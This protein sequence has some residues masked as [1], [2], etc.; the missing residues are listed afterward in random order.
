[1]ALKTHEKQ[2]LLTRLNEHSILTLIKSIKPVSRTSTPKNGLSA[3][4]RRCK[5]NSDD[6]D[7]WTCEGDLKYNGAGYAVSF[8]SRHRRDSDPLSGGTVQVNLG[9][10]KVESLYA[11]IQAGW[12]RR[13]QLLSLHRD[14]SF[15][16]GKIKKLSELNVF[17]KRSRLWQIFLTALI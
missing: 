7:E 12:Y 9:R 10:K 4:C 5:G 16:M 3:S 13:I 14:E 11:G 17:A 6:L 15:F 2:G 8:E 1:M